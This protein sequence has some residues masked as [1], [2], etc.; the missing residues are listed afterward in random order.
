MADGGQDEIDGITAAAVM[1]G[2]H[3][4]G[5]L[6]AAPAADAG[7]GVFDI[8]VVAGAPGSRL[9]PLLKRLRDGQAVEELRVLRSSHLTA[10]PVMETSRPVWVETDGEAIGVLPASFQIAPRVLRLRA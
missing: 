9:R 8:A 6:K 1:N 10:T 3:F 2:A 5:G 7:D 4:G